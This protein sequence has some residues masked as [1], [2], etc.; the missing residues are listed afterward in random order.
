VCGALLT[1]CGVTPLTNRIN[2]GEEPFVIAVGEG[3]DGM[4]D[5]Y[6]APAGAGSFQRL[7]F[8]RLE[9]RTPRLSPDGFTV[10]FLRRDAR[11]GSSSWALVFLNL[12]SYAERSVPIPAGAGEP[13]RLGWSRDGR[14]VVLSAG[15]LFTTPAPP[16]AVSLAPVAATFR[17]RADSD[18]YQLLGEPPQGSIRHCAEG[19]L[20]ISARTGAITPLGGGVT[21]AVRW[22]ADS[23]GYFTP[24]GFEVRPLGGGRSRRP[25]WSSAPSRLRDPTYHPGAPITG[26]P[27]VAGVR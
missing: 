23:V 16:E 10:A 15:G 6:A 24:H 7:S 4:T 25:V 27:G 22:G 20:C 13:E 1:G 18:S 12:H 19:G 9:E 3:P 8:N 17:E 5:L 11:G 26:S 2:I 21:D 14:R